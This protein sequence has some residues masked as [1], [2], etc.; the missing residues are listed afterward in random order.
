MIRALNTG[1]QGM[2]QFQTAL[3]VIGNN[4]ANINTVGFKGS[5]VDFADTLNQTLRAP[6]PDIDGKMSGAAGIQV[7][8]G[9]VISTIKNSFS[10][11]A[12][13]Q[14]GVPSDMAI[15]GDGFFLL[16]DPVSG[17]V[18]ASRAGDFREDNQGNLVNN[19]GLRLQ[20]IAD[21]MNA[22]TTV[23]DIKVDRGTYAASATISS[24]DTTTDEITLGAGHGLVTGKQVNFATTGTLPTATPAL[25]VGIA[26]FGRVTGNI[27][28][29]HTTAA[30][31]AADS[32]KVNFTGVGTG[33]HSLAPGASVSSWS[34]GGDGKV[35]M[36]LTDGTQYVRGQV[37]LQKFTNS[38]ALM[39][40]G[41]NL[42][43]NLNAAGALTSPIYTASSDILAR[44]GAPQSQGL[45]RIESGSLE[46]SNVDMAKEFATMI[47]TQRAFQANARV[48]T[49]SDEVL[50]E[51]MQ[52]KR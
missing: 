5:R 38:Q 45:G 17:E 44:A 19:T 34:V 39:R 10:Q 47:T 49:T 40:Q 24:L 20:G 7:G 46:L 6:T 15:A 12:V 25:S 43:S 14:T 52:L 18:F 23:G 33:T 32:D 8:N 22:S 41:Q 36:L 11:G 13:S 27:V 37:L 1:V 26:Y 2:R 50:M 30:G 42:Y 9:S 4:L 51:M 48:I 3:D 28:T 29:L 31:A 35:N 16:K 21:M